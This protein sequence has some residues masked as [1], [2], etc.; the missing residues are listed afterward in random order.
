MRKSIG[1]GAKHA[2]ARGVAASIEALG[3]EF[4]QK[5]EWLVDELCDVCKE[6]S[7]FYPVQVTQDGTPLMPEDEDQGVTAFLCS[8]CREIS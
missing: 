4:T 7:K 6:P 1:S 2:L 3:E 5:K 8:K